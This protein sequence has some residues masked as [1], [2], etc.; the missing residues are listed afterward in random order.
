VDTEKKNIDWRIIAITVVIALV[1]AGA[2]GGGVW[3]YMDQNAESITD[4]NTKSKDALRKEIDELSKKTTSPTATATTADKST[5]G[6]YQNNK[7][8]FQLTIPD[9]WTDYSI[10]DLSD[11]N[12]DSQYTLGNQGVI[13]FYLPTKTINSQ[14]A[15]DDFHCYYNYVFDIYVFTPDQWSKQPT[16]GPRPTE[17]GRNSKF[18]FA[19][20]RTNGITNP[21]GMTEDQMNLDITAILASYKSL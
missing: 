6:V 12:Y 17:I 14:Y 16:S 18:V 1:T 19:S 2:I 7:D 21:S 10:T 20:M 5:K 9:T 4:S 3:Y 11:K 15:N 13:T 8:G